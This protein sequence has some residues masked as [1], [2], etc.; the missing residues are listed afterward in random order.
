MEDI[1]IKIKELFKEAGNG[2]NYIAYGRKTTNGIPTGELAIIYGVEEKKPLSELSTEEIIP[3]IIT[4]DSADIKT[5]VFVM[6]KAELIACSCGSSS[7][8]GVDNRAMVRPLKGGLSVTSTNMIGYVGTFGFIAKHT[9]SGAIVGVSNNHVLIQ[10]AFYTQE[11]N[12]APPIKN[13]Y[14][15]TD[16]V[17]QHGEYS[18]GFTPPVGNVIGKVLGYV[19]ITALSPNQVDCSIF[20]INEIDVDATSVMQLGEDTYTTFLPFATPTELDDLLSDDPPLYSSGRT[21][22]PKGGVDNCDLRV[23]AIAGSFNISYMKQGVSTTITMEDQINYVKVNGVFGASTYPNPP[24]SMCQDP[25]MGGDSGS[26][27]IADYSGVRKIIGLVFAGGGS[28]YGA[29]TPYFHGFANRIDDVAS[30]IGIEAWDG[31]LSTAEYVD[32]NSIGYITTLNGSSNKT[33]NCNS[34]TYWQVGLTTLSN[35]C[36]P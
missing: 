7:G 23:F 24:Y 34:D 36:T 6:A 19:P 32:P 31:N 5:D 14:N 1:K 17:Y 22:G 12:L 15:P 20:S 2:V 11:R 33:L 18:P 26:A 35:P 29:G 16:Y 28:Y 30:Q 27:L 21:T 13:E 25:V 10:D 3:N 4:I 9:D 8:G